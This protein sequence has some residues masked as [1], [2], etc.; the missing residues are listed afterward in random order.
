MHRLLLYL[1]RKG[2]SIYDASKRCHV[3][4]PP[5]FTGLTPELELYTVLEKTLQ[6]IQGD[7]AAVMEQSVDGF[8]LIGSAEFQRLPDGEDGRPC[9]SVTLQLSY[10]LPGERRFDPQLG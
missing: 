10:Y 2:A 7:S 1:R 8:P 6:M 4:L 3:A 9:T 5:C